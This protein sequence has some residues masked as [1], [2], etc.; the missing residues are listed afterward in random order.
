VSGPVTLVAVIGPVEPAL[1]TAWCTHYRDLGVERFAVA[2][3]CPD[4]TGHARREELADTLRAATG[5]APQLLATGPWHERTN[6]ELRDQLRARAGSGWH[7]LADAD[8]F[9]QHPAGLVASLSVAESA[10]QGVL[11]G[12]LLDRI[13]ADGGFPAWT[14]AVG[15][16]HAYPLGG[17]LTH[18]LLRGD[19]RKIVLARADIAV[20]SGNHHAP[21]HRPTVEAVVPVHHFKWR[22]GIVAELRRRVEKFGTG[23][24]SETSPAV[25]HEAERLLRHL[26]DHGGRLDVTGRVVS[27]HPVTFVAIPAWWRACARSVVQGWQPPQPTR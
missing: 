12:L 18:E 17:L 3:H 1:L 24:W 10:G 7:L 9:Q 16:D 8:E 13:A 27:F 25:R 14:P 11:G 15:L 26:G 21:G 22:A 23:Q 5:A 2:L 4:T 6:G 19:P 20:A